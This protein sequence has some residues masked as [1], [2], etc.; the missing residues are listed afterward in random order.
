M[1]PSPAA[2]DKLNAELGAFSLL[3]TGFF[4]VGEVKRPTNHI[5]VAVIVELIE[6]IEASAMLACRP[7]TNDW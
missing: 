3:P 5:K 6:S 2:P 4:Y 7:V 1:G